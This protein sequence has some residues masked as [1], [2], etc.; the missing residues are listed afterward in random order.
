MGFLVQQLVGTSS[1]RASIVSRLPPPGGQADQVKAEGR[2]EDGGRLEDLAGLG[3]KALQAC[4]D[5][6]AHAA[7]QRQLVQG[8]PVVRLGADLPERPQRLQQEEGIAARSRVEP[9]GEQLIVL[10][11]ATVLRSRRRDVARRSRP[12][13][14]ISE[15]D[16][17]P[18]Q[19]L[20]QPGRAA[21]L[22]A[23][24]CPGDQQPMG[25]QLVAQVGQP[26]QCGRIAQFRSSR[27]RTQ[28]SDAGREPRHNGIA[29]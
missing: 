10:P 26:V 21:G 13:S 14:L 7:G 20:A 16:P 23:A 17:H 29:L 12:A 9:A 6:L 19:V 27:P 15:K 8:R 22:V 28:G 4:G 2:T 1:S 24:V 5:Y 11:G 25:T 18:G 3:M